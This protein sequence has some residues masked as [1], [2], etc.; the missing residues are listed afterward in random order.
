M[1]IELFTAPIIQEFRQKSHL[2]VQ[3]IQDPEARDNAR[4]GVEKMDEIER[5]VLEGIAA[6]RKRCLRFLVEDYEHWADDTR[7]I[8][9]SYV[10][11]LSLSERRAIGKAQPVTDAMHTL[12]VQYALSKFYATVNQGELSNRHS[13]LALDAGKE[14][15]DLLYTKQ[16]PRV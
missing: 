6:V 13:I 16:P 1:T 8:A 5:C 10:F 14:L 2:E 15:E 4:A 12:V 7:S 11:D 9:D 3:D